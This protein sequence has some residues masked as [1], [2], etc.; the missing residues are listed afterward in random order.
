MS[1]LIVDTV[2]ELH[3]EGQQAD[4]EDIG[5]EDHRGRVFTDGPPSPRAVS[6]RVVCL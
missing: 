3:T 4:T 6:G 1:C 5:P 2:R